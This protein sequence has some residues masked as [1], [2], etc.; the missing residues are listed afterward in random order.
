VIGIKYWCVLYP[1]LLGAAV[2]AETVGP[3]GTGPTGG[4]DVTYSNGELKI[5]ASKVS[6][7]DILNR[8]AALMHIRIDI[9]PDAVLRPIPFF[10]CG[11]A[12]PQEVLDSLLRTSHWNFAI[13]TKDANSNAI[14]TVLLFG[15]SNKTPEPEPVTR[16]PRSSFAVRSDAVPKTEGLD[17]GGQSQPQQQATDV[18][19]EVPADLPAKSETDPPAGSSE[20]SAQHTQAATS[21][22]PQSDG[23]SRP[24]ALAPPSSLNPQTIASQLQKMYQQR[25]QIVEPVRQTSS[26]DSSV[27]PNR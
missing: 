1:V 21:L 10:K 5:E 26:P 14:E 7:P 15:P 16:E 27:S 4:F 2:G 17:A 24:G 18:T 12:A 11:P 25:M 13:Q 20:A 8:V 9:P 6:L 22:L 23:Q 19:S 3:A